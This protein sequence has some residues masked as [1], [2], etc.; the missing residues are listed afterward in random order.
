M[1]FTL[2]QT[3]MARRWW[4]SGKLQPGERIKEPGSTLER[5]DR[6]LPK[7][8]VNGFGAVCTAVVMM[9]F[10][11]TKFNDGA[12]I[13]LLSTPILV[14]IFFAIH[15]H[16]K[17]VAKNLTLA[18]FNPPRYASRHRVL[19]LVSNVHR[20][21]LN[22][23][24]YARML[25]DDVTAVHVSMDPE[26]SHSVQQKWEQWGDGVRLVIIESPYR[27]LVE[28][29]LEYID[30]I[31]KLRQPGEM[32]TVVVPQ[33]VPE[34]PWAN[35]LHAQTALWLRMTLLFKPGIVITEVPYQVRD[36]KSLE[37]DTL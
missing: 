33:F 10:A 24:H 4:K 14:T 25:S 37:K 16:Y 13:V 5:D 21:S 18:N 2:S 36:A 26:Q 27:L 28:P 11:V 30:K 6:W 7:M 3:G 17:T 1:S 22:A 31:Y 8:V 12:W 23:L 32:I 29:L 19:L 15:R 35:L 34:R 9:V 20:G